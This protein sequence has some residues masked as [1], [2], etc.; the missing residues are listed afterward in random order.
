VDIVIE[1]GQ[2][3]IIGTEVKHSATPSS[4]NFKGLRILK[5]HLK[6]RSVRGLLIYTGNDVIPFEKTCMQCPYTILW[7]AIDD[8]LKMIRY[9]DI[10]NVGCNYCHRSW[11]Q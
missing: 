4:K 8:L 11:Y 3:Q 6:K 9:L 7:A 1:D 5:E 2:G 10:D